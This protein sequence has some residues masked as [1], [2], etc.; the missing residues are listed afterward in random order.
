M[1]TR[2]AASSA[3]GLAAALLALTLPLSAQETGFTWDNGTELGFVTTS[4]N[5]SQ[6]TFSLKSS[7]TGTGDPST[8]KIT[9]GGIRASSTTRTAQG[10][11]ADF[12]IIERDE[13][14][15]ENYFARS[16]YDHDLGQGFAF[17]GVGWERN[18]FAGFDNRFSI[19][20][21]F[22]RSWVDTETSRFKTDL[23]GTYTFQEDVGDAPKDDFGGLRATIEATRALSETTDLESTVVFDENLKDTDDFRVDW[24]S[25]VAV[26]LTEGLALKT[27]YQLFFDNAP[28][29]VQ[30][31]LV[32][33]GGNAAGKVAVRGDGIDTY[34]TLS[35]V[36][37]L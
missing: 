7:L 19:V 25:S 20:A 32:D 2:P 29:L 3:A 36:I 8:V 13:T 34:V 26:A 37:K 18:T 9:V 23:G 21:G 24:T 10:T 35:L 28:A 5:S 15:A 14:S 30:L 27:S 4:G 22:G 31:P 6:T 1:M 16:R 33:A 12:D 17:G 11:A